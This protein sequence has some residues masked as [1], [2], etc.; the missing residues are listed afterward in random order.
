MFGFKPKIRTSVEMIGRNEGI[1]VKIMFGLKN[2]VQK[3][4]ISK[5]KKKMHMRVSHQ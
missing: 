4:Y 2:R 3:C 1:F 5:K